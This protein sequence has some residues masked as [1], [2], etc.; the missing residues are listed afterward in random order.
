MFSL[1]PTP[2]SRSPPPPG[3]HSLLVYKISESCANKPQR[4]LHLIYLQ[5]N[6][7]KLKL[8]RKCNFA[9][10]VFHI[11]IRIPIR[12]HVSLGMLSTRSHMRGWRR[13]SRR[14]GGDM[15]LTF[16]RP[17]TRRR[18]QEVDSIGKD[19]AR[20]T[21]HEERS[22][23]GIKKKEWGGRGLQMEAKSMCLCERMTQIPCKASGRGVLK[24]RKKKSFY[25]QFSLLTGYLHAQHTPLHTLSTWFS[26][27]LCHSCEIKAF[28]YRQLHLRVGDQSKHRCSTFHIDS[29]FDSSWGVDATHKFVLKAMPH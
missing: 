10:R 8:L 12:S 23:Q 22:R 11:R 4:R 6:V 18:R 5:Q 19:V 26:F 14:R 15:Q 9:L 16:W 21:R 25:C 7:Q 20:N 13:R 24:C 2:P 1:Y 27:T 29:A 17:Q 28:A 3:V